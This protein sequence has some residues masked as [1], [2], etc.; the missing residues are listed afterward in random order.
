MNDYIGDLLFCE[1]YK[2]PAKTQLSPYQ[3]REIVYGTKQQLA[4][5]N[6]TSPQINKAGIKRVQRIVGSLFYYARAVDNKL[7]V[8]LSAIVSQQSTATANI[9]AAVHQIARLCCHISG[10]LYRLMR[11]RHGLGRPR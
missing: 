2:A 5:D 8:S 6:D 4:S 9:A 1:G 7:L 3:H 10:G 11:Q